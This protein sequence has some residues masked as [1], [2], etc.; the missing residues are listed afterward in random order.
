MNFAKSTFSGANGDECVE[1]AVVSDGVH[2]RD[3]KDR[4][5]A[6]L[7]FRHCDWAELVAAVAA[8]ASHP[9]VTRS[10]GGFA[11]V[12]P[13]GTLWFTPAEWEAFAAAARDGQCAPH[14]SSALSVAS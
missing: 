1:W 13:G 7:L 10:D 3:S 9:A 5:G 2:V 11:L 4:M 6:W 12:G 14:T 8:G